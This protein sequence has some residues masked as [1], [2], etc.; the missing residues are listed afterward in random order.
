V[1]GLQRLHALDAS[2]HAGKLPCQRRSLLRGAL[3]H[4]LVRSSCHCGSRLGGARLCERLLHRLGGDVSPRRLLLG[5]Q[6]DRI[7]VC[8]RLGRG[9]VRPDQRRV[10]FGSP[11]GRNL[12]VIA[13]GGARSV[14]AVT[15]VVTSVAAQVHVG[16]FPRNALTGHFVS[17][18]A[19]RCVG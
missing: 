16:A 17:Q 2:T 7:T 10:E 8:A 12:P 1:A 18:W 3:R 4:H 6:A 5:G 13:R 14:P 9:G 11:C 15:S 19:S